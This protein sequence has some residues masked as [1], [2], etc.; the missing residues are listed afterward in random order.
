MIL[1]ISLG[2]YILT[3]ALPFILGDAVWI[4]AFVY[5][6]LGIIINMYMIAAFS[7]VMAE[8]DFSKGLSS[9][10]KIGKRFYLKILIVMIAAYAPIYII[11]LIAGGF[12]HNPLFYLY[13]DL[14]W[15]VKLFGGVYSLVT[16]VFI[17]T[18]SMQNY[19]QDRDRYYKELQ[20]NG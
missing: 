2:V 7:S 15:A 3:F 17:S 4:M 20:G 11:G 10:F 1:G 19:L 12:F 9:S 6:V 8:D 14:H 13:S 5:I 18:Y 16:T